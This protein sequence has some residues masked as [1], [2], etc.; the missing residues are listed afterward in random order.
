MTQNSEIFDPYVEE[1]LSLVS[2]ACADLEIDFY[3]AGAVARDYHLSSIK[4][5]KPKR[6]TEDID[7]V[8]K[9]ANEEQFIALK[10][11]LISKGDFREHTEPIK[12]IY[13]DGF[14]LDLLPCGAI[15][16]NGETRL[17]QP[18]AFVLDMPG[19]ALL[20]EL[21]ISVE[22]NENVNARVCPL[23]G[24][25]LLKLLAWD[26]RKERTK[27]LFD[28]DTIIQMYFENHSSEVYD[29]YY[30]VLINNDSKNPDYTTIVCAEVIGI[31]LKQIL[32]PDTELRKRVIRILEID[33]RPFWEICYGELKAEMNYSD[34]K[35][36]CEIHSLLSKD[37]IDNFLMHYAAQKEKLEPVMDAALKKYR[38][39]ANEFEPSHVNMMKA[40]FIV[41]HVFKKG[42]AIR[43]ILNHS[44][45]KRLPDYQYPFLEKQSQ[46]PWRFTFCYIVENPEEGVF[47]MMDTMTYEEFIL[48]SPG[49]QEMLKETQPLM[50]FLLIGY[51]GKCWQSFGLNIP[52]RGYTVDDLFF[53]ATEL[54]PRIGDEETLMEEVERNPFPFFMLLCNADMP[55]VVSRGHETAFFQGEHD[56][57]AFS[58]EKLKEFF[59]TAWSHDVYRLTSKT[60]GEFPHLAIA[61]INERTHSI[62]T[63]AMTEFGYVTLVSELELAGI[64]LEAR[65]DIRVTAAMLLATRKIL[66]KKVELNPYEAMF[67][68]RMSPEE[69]EQ[70]KKLNAFMSMI[71]PLYNS[72]EKIDIPKLAKEAGVDEET[73]QD[74]WKK[75]KKQWDGMRETK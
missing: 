47:K 68:Q 36:H 20:N 54:N 29:T 26:N 16:E 60:H 50:W 38:H 6:V 32:E 11:L 51:N 24:I 43:K 49:I 8:V 27:D 73:A 59:D 4:D 40:E 37:V 14:E 66:N 44:E 57:S 17:T 12:L 75:V 19:F 63:S 72:G 52:F 35:K 56:V 21:A 2:N 53:F 30:D 64:H 33:K 39:V 3:L 42:G 10:E 13:K 9:V 15:E 58:P 7:V 69:T 5:Y 25:V 46:Q 48:V 61:Y 1:I 67:E 45:I 23:E 31:K 62:T 74:L 22:W 70:L 34:L 41:H 71:L 55:T 28:I 65:P 18:K